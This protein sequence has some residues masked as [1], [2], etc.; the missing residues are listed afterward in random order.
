MTRSR[1]LRRGPGKPLALACARRTLAKRFAL[2]ALVGLTTVVPGPGPVAADDLRHSFSVGQSFVVPGSQ[3]LPHRRVV[4]VAVGDPAFL[5]PDHE[6]RFCTQLQWSHPFFVDGER[7]V[8]FRMQPRVLRRGRPVKLRVL[9]RS[10][11][12]TTLG[13]HLDCLNAKVRLRVGDLVRWKFRLRQTNS[14]S[15]RTRVS[16]V[17]VVFGVSG[18]ESAAALQSAA[19]PPLAS[20]RAGSRGGR[21]ELINTWGDAGISFWVEEE[22]EKVPQRDPVFRVDVE[23]LGAGGVTSVARMTENTCQPAA[24]PLAVGDVVR[25]FFHVTRSQTLRPGYDSNWVD[26]F[27]AIGPPPG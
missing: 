12:T 9:E 22:E 8:D 19:D 13:S 21:Y 15:P 10:R 11:S 7:E 1:P 6:Y 4:A 5:R 25:W 17:A 20:L 24:F 14:D 3:V 18:R 23:V 2:P 27:G 16:L 26:L